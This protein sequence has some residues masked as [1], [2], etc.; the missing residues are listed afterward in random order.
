MGP[1]AF[2]VRFMGPTWA[3]M[4]MV[5][6][7]GPNMGPNLGL[8]DNNVAFRGDEKEFL[9]RIGWP[10]CL[11]SPFRARARAGPKLGPN[12]SQRPKFGHCDKWPFL[13]SSFF[14]DWGAWK[15]MA[16]RKI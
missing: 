14:A 4:L 3:H 9:S 15:A 1:L 7:Y 8:C 10:A 13:S 12:W 5:R 11:M 6:P 16:A 2:R